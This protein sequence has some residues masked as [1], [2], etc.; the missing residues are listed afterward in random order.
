MK[1]NFRKELDKSRNFPPQFDFKTL[2]RGPP[3]APRPVAPLSARQGLLFSY[4]S[5]N[6]LDGAAE[7]LVLLGI[8]VLE[9][10]LELHR[11]EEV[12]LLLGRGLQQLV[13]ALVEDFLRDFRPKTEKAKFDESSQNNFRLFL[14]GFYW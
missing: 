13:D 6:I 2:S 14:V 9:S 4:Q 5:S 8:V 7:T 1:K 10:N 12:A 3:Q 11:L